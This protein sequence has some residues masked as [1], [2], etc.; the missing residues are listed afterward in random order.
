MTSVETIPQITYALNFLLFYDA[1]MT[2]HKTSTLKPA[3]DNN[4]AISVFIFQIYSNLVDYGK[5]REREI[6][7][8]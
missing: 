6:K 7:T 1:L 3:S 2:S 5:V 4:Y 8:L